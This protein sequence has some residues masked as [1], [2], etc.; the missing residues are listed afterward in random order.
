MD[1]LILSEIPRDPPDY[2]RWVSILDNKLAMALAMIAAVESGGGSGFAFM[3]FLGLLVYSNS[4]YWRPGGPLGD[5]EEFLSGLKADLRARLR[6]GQNIV[7]AGYFNAKSKSWN[8][9]TDDARGG[10]LRLFVASLSL[11]PEN[12]GPVPTFA[13]TN[14][15]S[16]ID[17][18]FARLPRRSSISGW[19][20]RDDE[21]SDTDH[22]YIE[23][24]LSLATPPSS[25]P[26]LNG[27]VI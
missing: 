18:T 9:G 23:F 15:S 22:R 10:A 7:V 13:W 21:Y 3:Q 24:T 2:P 8:S 4:C 14:G 5:F 12:V 27:W 25:R 26:L 11:W 1:L 17:V 16:V 6:P 19:R 20:I